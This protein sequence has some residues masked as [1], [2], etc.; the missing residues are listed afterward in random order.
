M[1]FFFAILTIKRIPSK[2]NSLETLQSETNTAD[3]LFSVSYHPHNQRCISF[4]LCDQ[5]LEKHKRCAALDPY[6]PI[7]RINVLDSLKKTLL[8]FIQTLFFG[9]SRH[10]YIQRPYCKG[11]IEVRVSFET[12]EIESTSFVVFRIKNFYSALV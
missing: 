9:I 8:S 6:D 4:H 3:D 1:F 11:F 7:I 10:N 12:S 2:K 5:P